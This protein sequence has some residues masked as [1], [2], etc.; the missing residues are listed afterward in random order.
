[1]KKLVVGGAGYIGS[2]TVKTLLDSGYEV[3]ILDN[4]STGYRELI[5][6]RA[7][8]VEG[9]Y[10]NYECVTELFTT[11]A[12]D[13]VFL[14][15]SKLV[16][17]ESVAKPLYYFQE[18][19]GKLLMFLESIRPY[20]VQHIVFSSS[21]SVYG[22]ASDQN[23]DETVL[24]DPQSPYASTKQIIEDILRWTALEFGYTY[25]FL[26]YFNVAGADENLKLGLRVKEPTHIVPAVTR[27]IIEGRTVK[28]FGNDY[29]TADGTC[30]RDFIHIVDLA[31][32]HM[33]AYEYLNSGNPSDVFNLGSQKGYSVLEV[34]QETERVLDTTVSYEF[35]E[36]RQ[37]DPARVVADT[38]KAKE[39]LGFVPEYS[40]GEIIT[41][42]YYFRRN[43]IQ[44]AEKQ[45]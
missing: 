42:D 5:D 34:I 6:E 1:M 22:N 13:T 31:R 33:K 36:R 40:L 8:F 38:T 9:D 2:Q 37:G 14:F 43:M 11:Y 45:K 12:I 18:N 17:S 26:R 7:I 4:L 23:L 19:I 15:A 3:I 28:I 35:S 20:K 21:A 39:K 30:V 10:N 27:S 41:S 25:V 29:P 44:N 32:A 24:L 16:V